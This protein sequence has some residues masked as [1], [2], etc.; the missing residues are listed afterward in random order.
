MNGAGAALKKAAVAGL[1]VRRQAKSGKAALRGNVAFAESCGDNARGQP[2]PPCDTVK[3]I[4]GKNQV[5][6]FAAA[7]AA[8]CTNKR[9]RIARCQGGAELPGFGAAAGLYDH[10]HTSQGFS[11]P[12]AKSATA[13]K[14]LCTML[15]TLTSV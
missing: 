3:V 1:G 14:A 5:A 15:A 12:A 2:Q 7:V 10:R 13:S 4:P 11:R 9:K 6:P 8:S